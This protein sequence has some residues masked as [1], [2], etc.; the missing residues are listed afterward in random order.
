MYC[1]ERVNDNP[2]DAQAE[3]VRNTRLLT[4]RRHPDAD[5]CDRVQPDRDSSGH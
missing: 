2:D 1:S 5:A 4:L 3:V